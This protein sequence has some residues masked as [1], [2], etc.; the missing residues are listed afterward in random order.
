MALFSD[1][2]IRTASIIADDTSELIVIDRELYNRSVQSVLRQEFED[3]QNFITK[4][5]LFSSWAPRYKKQLAMALQK[6]T[7]PYEGVP[8]K[9][10]T[11]VT[12]IYFIL[13]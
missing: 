3:K 11:Q 1:D 10:G 5:P 12:A 6:E 4:N 8:T 9:Q 2:C 13:S 7:L